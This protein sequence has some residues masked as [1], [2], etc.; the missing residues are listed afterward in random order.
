MSKLYCSTY[1]YFGSV[2]GAKVGDPFAAAVREALWVRPGGS[3]IPPA[4]NG[5]ELSPQVGAVPL[6]VQP[7]P[8]AVVPFNVLNGVRYPL[9]VAVKGVVARL[10]TSLSGFRPNDT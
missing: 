6:N 1:P 8:F 3:T 2:Q 4:P 7:T 10:I 9:V 5:P